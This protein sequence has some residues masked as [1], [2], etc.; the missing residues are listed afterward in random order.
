MC[1]IP[2][3]NS[4]YPQACETLKKTGTNAPENVNHTQSKEKNKQ[5]DT[6]ENSEEHLRC[7]SPANVINLA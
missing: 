7:C 6:S 3:K 1:Q 5:M 2:S 4:Q